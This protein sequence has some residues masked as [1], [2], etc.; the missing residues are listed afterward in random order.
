MKNTKGFSV[1]EVLVCLVVLGVAIG[2]TMPTV[3]AIRNRWSATPKAEE[4]SQPRKNVWY[5]PET[6]LLVRDALADRWAEAFL[7]SIESQEHQSQLRSSAEFK[8][9]VRQAF[10]NT[11][12]VQYALI[13][14]FDLTP[15]QKARGEDAN[16]K[17][18][19]NITKQPWYK[20]GL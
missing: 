9:F 1:V 8:R 11:D 6:S 19:E 13:N 4:M 3:N 7:G 16:R 18:A 17:L 20:P 10:Q 12:L 15:G 5:S 2:I 14:K